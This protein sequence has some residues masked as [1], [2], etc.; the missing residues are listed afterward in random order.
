MQIPEVLSRRDEKRRG[1]VS[2][3]GKGVFWRLVKTLLAI[4]QPAL[5]L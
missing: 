4:L 1:V 5:H 2:A 3:D